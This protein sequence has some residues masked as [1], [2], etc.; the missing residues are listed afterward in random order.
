VS[1]KNLC[2]MWETWYDGKTICFTLTDLG[3]SKLK[4]VQDNGDTGIA[5]IGN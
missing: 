4:W 1:G 5:R 2:Q 3:G